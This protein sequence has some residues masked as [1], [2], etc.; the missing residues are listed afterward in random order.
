[1]RMSNGKEIN[2]AVITDITQRVR[3]KEKLGRMD[4]LFFE[5]VGLFRG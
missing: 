5:A 4:S 2:V 1:M 3:A